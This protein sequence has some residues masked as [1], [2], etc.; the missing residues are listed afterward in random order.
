MAKNSINRF[1]KKYDKTC[2]IAESILEYSLFLPEITPIRSKNEKDWVPEAMHQCYVNCH[3]NLF[4][5]TQ[6]HFLGFKLTSVNIDGVKIGDYVPDLKKDNIDSECITP[7]FFAKTLLSHCVMAAYDATMRLLPFN[8]DI[9]SYTFGKIKNHGFHKMLEEN[10][11]DIS[12]FTIRR[13]NDPKIS[14][15]T[16]DKI[17]KLNQ[18]SNQKSLLDSH[19]GIFKLESFKNFFG[20]EK[21]KAISIYSADVLSSLVDINSRAFQHFC[22]LYIKDA[23]ET[24]ADDLYKNWKHFREFYKNLYVDMT[25]K[26]FWANDVD[27]LYYYYKMENIFGLDL[28]DNIF[29]EIKILKKSK[30]FFPDGINNFKTL[31]EIGR[32]PNV[33]SRNFYLRNAFEYIKEEVYINNSC[34][35]NSTSAKAWEETVSLY[36]LFN[37]NEWMLAFEK[38]C[39][40]F[41]RLVFPAEEW[42]FFLT[43]MKTVD[44]HMGK[45]LKLANKALKLNE[46]LTAYIHDNAE[47]IAY[48]SDKH[49]KEFKM[50]EKRWSSAGKPDVKRLLLLYNDVQQHKEFPLSSLNKENL[51]PKQDED[52][53]S[54][55]PTA[56]DIY[57]KAF[58]QNYITTITDT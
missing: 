56:H 30:K 45:N 36:N 7:D 2:K 13:L 58:M 31:A 35:L 15:V 57:Y 4:C 16:R 51:L 10:L 17:E 26:D 27:K 41:N 28:I 19:N 24:K 47:F 37:I 39:K 49:F 55:K 21:G 11:V 8:K 5:Q 48:P 50:P 32:F 23:G 25:E 38:F 9:S 53:S 29:H 52:V 33:F 54:G 34:F 18:L 3:R 12:N 14:Q 42:Y 22:Q 6:Y 44:K 20:I 1:T 43:L 40:F 46:V